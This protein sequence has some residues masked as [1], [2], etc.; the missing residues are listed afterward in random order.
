VVLTNY[1]GIGTQTLA[2]VADRS[3]YKQGKLM[4]GMHLPV[5]PASAVMERRPEYLLVL[6]WNF[7]DEIAR[8]LDAYAQ[9]GGRFVLPV[10]EPRL[11]AGAGS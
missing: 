7:F 10:P 3:Q 11:A 4:P 6:A 1:C 5:V 9:A 8:Q 2:F